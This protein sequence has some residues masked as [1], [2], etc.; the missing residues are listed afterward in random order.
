MGCPFWLNG[1][2]GHSKFVGMNCETPQV[3]EGKIAILVKCKS[4]L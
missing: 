3:P 1:A 4:K 2:L